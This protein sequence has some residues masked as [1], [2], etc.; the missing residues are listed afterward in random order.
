MRN[1]EIE[2]GREK[3]EFGKEEA[4]GIGRWGDRKFPINEMDLINPIN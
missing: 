4:E 2:R 1:A 3:G